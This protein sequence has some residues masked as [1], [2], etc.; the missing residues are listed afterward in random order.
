MPGPVSVIGWPGAPDADASQRPL[1]W[2]Y[3]PAPTAMVSPGL[4]DVRAVSSCVVVVTSQRS[5]VELDGVGSGEGVGV[6]VG[7]GAHRWRGC[8]ACRPDGRCRIKPHIGAA[9]SSGLH[10]RHRTRHRERPRAHGRRTEIGGG[11]VGVVIPLNLRRACGRGL[12]RH[13]RTG[14]DDRRQRCRRR[15]VGEQRTTDQ[16]ECSTQPDGDA[17][18]RPLGSHNRPSLSMVRKELT[19]HIFQS[20]R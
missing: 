18:D 8:W 1:L 20:S 7:V 19:R 4:A 10:S 17:K 5:P 12:H 11:A 9:H 2:L 14:E 15:G 16:R 13:C 3:V 6:I